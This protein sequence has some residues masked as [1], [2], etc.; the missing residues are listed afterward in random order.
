MHRKNIYIL[1]K[2]QFAF[3]NGFCMHDSLRSFYYFYKHFELIGEEKMKNEDK[4]KAR[5]QRAL[6]KTKV[7]IHNR[8]PMMYDNNIITSHDLSQVGKLI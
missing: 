6:M 2:S 1:E 4:K 8:R 5:Y 3:E 7:I